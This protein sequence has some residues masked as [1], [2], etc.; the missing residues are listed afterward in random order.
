MNHF[1]DKG[2]EIIR[3]KKILYYTINLKKKKKETIIAPLLQ[4]KI[5]F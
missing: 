3:H 5:H 1:E 4:N 2:H